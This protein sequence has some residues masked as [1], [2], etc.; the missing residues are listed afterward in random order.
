MEKSNGW[1]LEWTGETTTMKRNVREYL[2]QNRFHFR[3]DSCFCSGDALAG[4]GQRISLLLGVVQQVD[5]S[6]FDGAYY[7]SFFHV[8]VRV[9]P[10][11]SSFVIFRIPNFA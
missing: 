11:H 6:V 2:S 3:A 5:L 10:F 4:K 7:R 8:C 1:N 9:F